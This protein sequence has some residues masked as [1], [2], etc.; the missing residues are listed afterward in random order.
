MKK[1]IT[2]FM[3]TLMLGALAACSDNSEE[4]VIQE[5]QQ[6]D[7]I[8]VGTRIGDFIV[9]Y[10]WFKGSKVPIY[11]HDTS[12]MIIYHSEDEDSII[13]KLEE[14]GL[15]KDDIKSKVDYTINP[16][17]FENPQQAVLAYQDTKRA[18][19][20]I[21]YEK[22]LEISEVIYATPCVSNDIIP[23]AV[24]PMSNFVYVDGN[25]FFKIE[26][27]AKELSVDILGKISG[28]VGNYYEIACNKDSKGNPLEV[29]NAFHDAGFVSEPA[30]IS[31]GGAS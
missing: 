10:Y 15:T 30:F 11:L 8:P 16:N 29:A 26:K 5:I 21:N 6:E 25:D 20:S 23:E 7:I 31:G 1:F 19:I 4:L 13:A 24:F 2:F 27:I 12:C 9:S 22:A 14:I 17:E 28:I 3:L 18:T